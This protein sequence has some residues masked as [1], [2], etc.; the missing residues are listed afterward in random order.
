VSGATDR[1]GQVALPL[2]LPAREVAYL[3]RGAVVRGDPEAVLCGV[4]IDSRAVSRGML[5]VALRGSRTDGHRYV[6][7]ALRAGARGAL[8]ST[9]VPEAPEGSVLVR[10]EDTL[11]AFQR[12]ARAIRDRMGLHVVGITGS[13]G[14]T[15][16]KEMAASVA[17]RAYRTARSPENWN[18]EIGVPLVL[19]N[20]PRDRE[21]AVLELAM[22]GPGQI[23]EL[24]EICRPT[25]GVLTTVGHSHLDFFE[26]REELAQAKGELLEGIGPGGVAIANAD[27]PLARAQLSR[28]RGRRLTFGLRAGDV[29]AED[30]RPRGLGGT[31]FRLRTPDGTAQVSLAVPGLHAVYNA[32]AAAAVGTALGMAP[33][34]IARGLEETRPLPMRLQVRRVRG[35]T[36]LDDTYN[37][38]PQ[39][40]E[41]AL[42]VLS[43][44]SASPRIAVL[45]DMKELGKHSV[46]AHRQV[47]ALAARSGVDL[48][49]A[50]GPAS[51]ETA[52]AAREAGLRHVVHTTDLEEV[53]GLL[54]DAAVPGAVVLVK[55][56]RVMAMERILHGLGWAGDES[57][58]GGP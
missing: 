30:V 49:I 57:G 58:G 51:E 24:V 40:V 44:T 1:G 48:L 53:V 43:G 47:G 35:V 23:R 42:D 3:A 19:A 14:K 39:S 20:L 28:S 15:T 38:S 16:T 56:S 26:S 8:V 31:T 41:A 52:R 6:G 7:D 5:F 33:S 50:Y 12:L 32:L 2:S 46:D 21:V 11:A 4:A 45:G 25:V 13:V 37:S 27:D 55:G 36:V 10:V 22:R 29:T 9:D 34:E 17:A 18:T 54:R